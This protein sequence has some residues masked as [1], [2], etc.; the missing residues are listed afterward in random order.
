[1]AHGSLWIHDRRYDLV[2]YAVRPVVLFA[3]FFRLSA[4]LGPR[5]PMLVYIASASFTGIPHW[6]HLTG[7]GPVVAE[8]E[9]TPVP[10]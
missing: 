4:A 8:P 6:R 5:G 9:A 1:M 2:W 3:F 10:A 7:P